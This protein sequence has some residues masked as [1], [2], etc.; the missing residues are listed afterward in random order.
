MSKSKKQRKPQ[1]PGRCVFCNGTGLSKEHIWDNW[2]KDVIPAHPDRA[3]HTQSRL[4]MLDNHSTKELYLLPS[5]V[6]RQGSFCQRK[7]RNVCRKCNNEWMSQIVNLAK[8][9]AKHMILDEPVELDREAQKYVAAWIAIIT[10]MAEFTD[11]PTAGIPAADRTVLFETKQPPS[12]WVIFVAPFVGAEWSP[13]GYRHHGM[14][15][16]KRAKEP[17][18]GA[19]MKLADDT[20]QATTC[21]LGALLFHV[22]SSTDEGVRHIFHQVTA[23]GKLCRLWPISSDVIHWPDGPILGDAVADFIADSFC[24]EFGKA[25]RHS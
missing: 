17:Q 22:F 11:A 4:H 15:L 9:F 6:F 10:I 5:A 16:K 14:R 19:A 21:T 8:P 13:A 20:L 1:E 2:L 3:G 25:V 18:A 24:T 7:L 23:E 12:S